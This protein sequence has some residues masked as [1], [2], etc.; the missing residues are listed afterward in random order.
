[1]DMD[2]FGLV[3]IPAGTTDVDMICNGTIVPNSNIGYD[4][5]KL[6]KL[7]RGYNMWTAYAEEQIFI[8]KEENCWIRKATGRT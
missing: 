1:M 3:D 2:F 7:K 6:P 4:E 8:Y 5:T